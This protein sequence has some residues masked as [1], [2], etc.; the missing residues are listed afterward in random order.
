MG[1]RTMFWVLLGFVLSRTI[2]C[3]AQFTEFLS[4]TFRSLFVGH[5][6]TIRDQ[7]AIYKEYD[8]IVVGAGSGGSVVANRL[9]E[10]PSWSV[11][12]LEAGQDEIFL[13]DVPLTASILSI[14]GYNWG[15]K[16]QKLKTAC[17]GHVEERCN[18]ARGKGLGGTSI[19]NF[20]IYSRG[21]KEDFNMWE[22]MGNAGWSYPEVL[23]Y[24]IKSENCSIYENIDEQF[25]GRSGY[26]YVETPQ[27]ESPFLERFI[28]AGKD[29]GYENVDLNG[30]S[31]LGFGKV[32][33]TL[34]NGRRCSASKAFLRPVAHRPNLHISIHSRVTKI[35]IDPIQKWAYGVQFTKDKLKYTILAKKE[36]ILSAGAIN[37]AQLLML[38]GVGPK[39]HLKNL[40]IE[41]LADLPVGYNFQDHLAMSA[42][43]IFVNESVTISDLSVQNPRDVFNYLARGKGP[44]TVPGGAEALAFLKTKYADKGDAYPDIELVLGAGALNGDVYGGFRSLLGIPERTFQKIYAPYIGTP[45][46]SIAVVLLRPESRGRVMLKDSNPWHWPV[47]YP[48]YL[49]EDRDVQ[50]MV[51]GIKM[52]ISITQS[53]HFKRY[54]ATPRLLPF[55]NCEHLVLGSD[56]Y[57]TCSLR[58][59]ATTLGHHV[60][61]CKMGPV[62]DPSSVVDS[63]LRVHG[64][65][66]LRVVDASI[67]PNIVAGH[68]NAVI[69]MIGEK[70]SDMIK[71][72][73]E[74]EVR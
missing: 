25:H 3:E 65:R 74:Y 17:L 64:I 73:W 56:E 59:L 49:S 57:W 28:K 70:A 40:G 58:Q 12:L 41:V 51:E 71:G 52:A 35:L 29:L 69:F 6:N 14:T 66:N 38:S 48:N 33:A 9:T 32:Q 11:L 67:M 63:Q 16:S 8:F 31:G 30:N 42:I 19:L 20:M 62:E 53:D 72:S 61:T 18:M 10:N 46:F 45:S 43:P 36:V 24:F 21:N 13:T 22:K 39:E 44:F 26:L 60:G 47:I 50:T 37:S 2:L 34:K 15:Y 5:E 23:P 68:T 1:Q 55:P 27:Y 54:N 7:S 4:R